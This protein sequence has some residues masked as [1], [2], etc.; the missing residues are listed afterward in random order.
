MREFALVAILCVVG[1]FLG[2]YQTAERNNNRI[3]VFGQAANAAVRPI[4]TVGAR[5]VT[6]TTAFLYG[7]TNASRLESENQ[8]L[9]SLASS[10]DLYNVTLERLQNE[11]DNLRRLANY[12]A[13]E[14]RIKI[15]AE[16]TGFF[17][18]EARIS[19]NVGLKQGVRPGLP[20]VTA[21]GLL[22]TIQTAEAETSQ[23]LLISSP[24]E[25]L[26]AMA[27]RNPPAAGLLRGENAT[28]LFLEF[29]DPAAPVKVG[30]AVVTSGFSEH[31]PR[32]I[33]IGIVVQVEDNKEFGS[34]R[35]QVFPNAIIGSS[36]EVLVLK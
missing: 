24:R 25:K 3:D 15:P 29:F 26:G 12:K 1:F 5:A 21:D 16:V 19:L 14:N 18:H 13:P 23:A 10:A 11:V 17:Q 31:I 34:R 22:A 8:R 28:A 20:V 7:L 4:A 27:L 30:D 35:A 32:G 6:A 2:R 33:P 36:R 9:S